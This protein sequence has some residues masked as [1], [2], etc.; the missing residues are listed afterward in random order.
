MTVSLSSLAAQRDVGARLTLS[1]IGVLVPMIAL[2]RVVAHGPVLGITLAA[3]GVAGG[4]VVIGRWAGASPTMRMLSGVALMTQVSLLVAAMSGHPWQIDMHMAYFAALA[5]LVIYCDWMVIVTAAAAVAVH[6][7]VLSFVLPDAVFPGSGGIVRV[8]VHAVILIVEAGTLIWVT[9]SV[10]QMFEAASKAR[11]D[12]ERAASVAVQANSQA[13]QVRD[14]ADSERA[15]ADA[16]RRT[17][18]QQQDQVV[19]ALAE[20]LSH[21]AQGDL[22]YAIRHDFDGR[23]RQLRDDFNSSM[24]TLRSTLAAI[25][26]NATAVSNGTEEIARA[27]DDLSRRTEQQAQGLGE[28]ATALDQ[29]TATVKRTAEGARQANEAVGAAKAEA[30]H[31]SDVVSGA[32][33]AMGEIEKSSQQISQI[34]GVI[35]E[36]AFQTNLLALNAGVEAARAGDAGR[37][38]AV[39]AQEVRA[40]AQRTA[41]AAREIKALISASSQQVGQGVSMVDETGKALQAIV[42]RVSEIDA[43]VR[44]IAASAQEQ[45]AGLAEVNATVSH[46]DQVVQQNTAMVAQSAA[47]SHNLKAEADDLSKLISRFSLRDHASAHQDRTAA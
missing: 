23:Y 11:E 31:S 20:G 10:N 38:F 4:A 1:L 17:T 6:H 42:T 21:L 5:A 37:G 22:V 3:V 24:E 2:A 8:L 43:L 12:A 35:D 44:E 15:S 40:L 25:S 19:N 39:V 16:V 29:I 14:L 45:A 47:A 30:L 9:F 34:I 7:L 28:T 41:E 13:E 36:I 32:V 26:A 18:E 46:M 33:S 27:S